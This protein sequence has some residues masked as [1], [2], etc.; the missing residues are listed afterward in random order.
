MCRRNI[1]KAEF[2]RGTSR[3]GVWLSVVHLSVHQSVRSGIV[4]VNTTSDRLIIEQLEHEITQKDRQRE[5]EKERDRQR[6]REG[7]RTWKRTKTDV[8]VSEYRE[9]KKKLQNMRGRQ[10]KNESVWGGVAWTKE[11][12]TGVTVREIWAMWD[13]E[14]RGGGWDAEKETDTKF[15][16]FIV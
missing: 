3:L 9:W 5:R 16:V 15:I 6:L 11:S 8:V 12:D 2:D 14:R 1:K 7:P 13:E 10:K 4:D